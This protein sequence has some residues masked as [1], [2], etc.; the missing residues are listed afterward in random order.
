MKIPHPALRAT[1]SRR[2]K[3]G[4][5]VVL[6]PPGEGGPKGRMREFKYPYALSNPSG[7]PGL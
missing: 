7:S 4:R 1:F 6:L 3:V 5:G 2:E